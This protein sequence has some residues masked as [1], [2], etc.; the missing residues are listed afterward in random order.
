MKKLY[1]SVVLTVLS[2]ISV[3]SQAARLLNLAQNYLNQHAAEFG[4]QENDCQE[5]EVRTNYINE[6]TQVEHAYLQQFYSGYPLYNAIANFSLKNGEIV[7]FTHT[8]ESNLH[9]RVNTSQPAL[10]LEQA[11][12]AGAQHF[13][14]VL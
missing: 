6:K 13:G 9:Q 14:M 4:C 8:L 11:A 1:F 12:N 10:S 7:Y 5:L 3:W 2:A